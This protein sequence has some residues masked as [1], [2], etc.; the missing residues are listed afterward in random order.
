MEGSL[1]K[2]D[3]EIGVDGV[4]RVGKSSWQRKYDVLSRYD[5]PRGIGGKMVVE[6]SDGNS[7]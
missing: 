7:E 1:L 2:A 4:G 5:L 3:N 6:E